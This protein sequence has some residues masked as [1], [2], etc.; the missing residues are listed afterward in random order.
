VNSTNAVPFTS[1]DEI[2]RALPRAI[3][4]LHAGR[5]VG[6][7]TETVYGLGST[8]ARD[9]V[10][11]LVALKQR[12]PDK[13]FLLLVAGLAMLEALGLHVTTAAEALA[14]RY[15]P[16]PLT[17][18]LAGGAAMPAPLRGPAGEVAVRWTSHPAMQRLI[19]AL[20]APVTSTSAN[21]PGLPSAASAQEIVS[22]WERNVASGELL[23]LD[24]GVLAAAEP[25]TLV[26]CSTTRP[27]L[28]RAGAISLEALRDVVPDLAGE[29]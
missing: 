27:R 17:L 13:P 5:L 6:H 15:W 18:V 25:S 7:P 14:S 1:P 12:T 10:A 11:R 21:L 20:G 3:E 22:V 4:Q 9:G 16:G 19:T 28:M 2:A 24:S 29:R 8:L 26:D 23:V